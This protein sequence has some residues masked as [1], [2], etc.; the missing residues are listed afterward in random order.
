MFVFTIF[1]RLLCA[2]LL[3]ITM[4]GL[5]ATSNTGSPT[6]HCTR[7]SQTFSQDEL[8]QRI[9]NLP[10]DLQ[11]VIGKKFLGTKAWAQAAHRRREAQRL[12]D[13]HDFSNQVQWASRPL[14]IPCFD[15]ES[16]TY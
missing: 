15:D 13:F 8:W 4:S 11:K 12:A 2:A 3:T 10:T 6:I 5:L 7:L 16:S 14:R 9:N 1:A